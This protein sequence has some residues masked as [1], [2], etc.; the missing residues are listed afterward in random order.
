MKSKAAAEEEDKGYA[1]RVQAQSIVPNTY[2]G[3]NEM[4][5]ASWIHG[6]SFFDP[7]PAT[8]RNG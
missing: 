1:A 6:F 8:L 2:S 4:L 5:S 7:S 3:A